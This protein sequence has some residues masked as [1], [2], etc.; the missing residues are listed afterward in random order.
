MSVWKSVKNNV[1][2]SNVNEKMLQAALPF[3]V[4]TASQVSD[5]QEFLIL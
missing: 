5:P 2:G 3:L 4:N 1:L